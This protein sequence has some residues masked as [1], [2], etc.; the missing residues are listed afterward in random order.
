[1]TTTP[2]SESQ[3]SQILRLGELLSRRIDRDAEMAASQNQ[4]KIVEN[5]AVLYRED[6]TV[7]DFFE[8]QKQMFVNNILAG[9][10]PS[11][12]K[13][14][15]GQNITAAKLLCS[16]PTNPV[17]SPSHRFHS[18]WAEFEQWANA[19]GLTPTWTYGHDGMGTSSR[20]TLCVSPA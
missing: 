13:V 12:V 8:D 15:D 7:R 19:N 16:Y 4:Q 18:V 11:S 1:M 9:R 5:L 14:G 3:P 17:T 20:Y 2:M 10:A 6:R